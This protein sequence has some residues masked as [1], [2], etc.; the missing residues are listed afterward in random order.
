MAVPSKEAKPLLAFIH[1][2]G[3]RFQGELGHLVSATMNAVH[4]LSPHWPKRQ[5]DDAQQRLDHLVGGLYVLHI[6]AIAE[7]AGVDRNVWKAG[8]EKADYEFILAAYHVRHSMGHRDNYGRANSYSAEFDKVMRS[9]RPF[10]GVRKV[11]PTVLQLD[12][13]AGRRCQEILSHLAHEAASKLS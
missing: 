12:S 3:T 7:E 1:T 5:Q 11:S 9:S 2:S 10:P 8:L 4:R 6:L 13:S